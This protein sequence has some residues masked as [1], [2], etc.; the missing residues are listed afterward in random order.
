[1]KKEVHMITTLSLIAVGSALLL[2]WV[3]SFTQPKIE[4][5]KRAKLKSVLAQ[6][7][8]IAQ[9][10]VPA[11]PDTVWFGVKEGDTVGIVF[12]VWPRGY[13]GPI[14]LTVGIDRELKIT[15][16]VPGEDLKET[17]GLGLKIREEWFREQ[18]IGKDE[19][20]AHLK[21]DGGEIDAI[22]AATISS[23]AVAEGVVEGIKRYCRYI[24]KDI[25]L[26]VYPEAESFVEIKKD[27][28]C[29]G[30]SGPD[31]VIIVITAGEGFGGPIR[32]GTVFRK[33]ELIRVRIISHSETPGYGSKITDTTFLNQIVAGRLEAITGATVS[34]QAVFD[35]VEKA[36]RIISEV[37]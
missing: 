32:V 36:K 9:E 21:Q 25:R 19:K 15:G 33:G 22:T 28:A 18:F 20:T 11:I 3:Y 37:K 6:A 10:F 17:P 12:K 4:A 34:S 5:D 27:T 2:S 13:G 8:P 1:M 16:L 29:Y 14:E 31:T 35:A 26:M 30:I 23:R 7:L 24:K